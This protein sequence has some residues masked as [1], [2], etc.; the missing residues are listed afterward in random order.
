MTEMTFPLRS[1][2]KRWTRVSVAVLSM[3]EER[4]RPLQKGTS[5]LQK[6]ILNVC[7]LRINLFQF[8]KKDFSNKHD[9]QLYLLSKCD[10]QV[11]SFW[12]IILAEWTW[13]R[14]VLQL[15]PRLARSRQHCGGGGSQNF[16]TRTNFF[17]QSRMR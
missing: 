3:E 8:L 12:Q 16:H 14:S 13:V 7:P 17:C 10:V 1:T 2:M 15:L 6:Y 4:H 9:N 11:T 5:L